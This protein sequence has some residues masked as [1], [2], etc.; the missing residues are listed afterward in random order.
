MA[1]QGWALIVPI[2]V[3]NIVVGCWTWVSAQRHA[4]FIAE[5]TAAGD[6]FFVAQASHPDF[7][8]ARA[9]S[10]ARAKAAILIGCG[11]V[12]L[13]VEFIVIG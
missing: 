4:R 1:V 9:V 5:K 13:M 3:F 7:P 6:P 12:L 8:G 2:A 10:S 11:V